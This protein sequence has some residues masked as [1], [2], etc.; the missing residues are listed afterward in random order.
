VD[1]RSDIT[2]SVLWLDNVWSDLYR[3]YVYI[4]LRTSL[5]STVITERHKTTL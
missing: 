4:E 5:E 2:L 3:Q 1:G